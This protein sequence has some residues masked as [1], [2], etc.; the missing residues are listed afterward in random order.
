MFVFAL[1]WIVK[2]YAEATMEVIRLITLLVKRLNNKVK[3]FLEL[4]EMI[5]KPLCIKLIDFLD[6]LME[7][8]R[9]A[10]R[11]SRRVFEGVK[12]LFEKLKSFFR[13]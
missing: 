10:A 5:V 13:K 11:L 7:V 4:L 1:R 12:V 9:Y 6:T 8:F 2:L 3:E